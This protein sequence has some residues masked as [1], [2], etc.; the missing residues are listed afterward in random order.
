MRF[1]LPGFLFLSLLVW[2]E[3]RLDRPLEIYPAS[4]ATWAE[5][6]LDDYAD[7]VVEE[8]RR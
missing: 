1:L 3:H 4:P 2:A 8:W 5:Q 7:G 6:D